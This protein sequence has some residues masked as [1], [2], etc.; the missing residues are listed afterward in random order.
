M[1]PS[2][3]M[4]GRERERRCRKRARDEIRTLKYRTGSGS[5]V[6]AITVGG[7]ISIQIRH[8]GSPGYTVPIDNVVIIEMVNC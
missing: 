5:R 3:C 8:L 7:R 1:Y 6:K 4:R 2:L